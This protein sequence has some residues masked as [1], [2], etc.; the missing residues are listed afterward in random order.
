MRVCVLYQPWA[1]LAARTL[2]RQALWLGVETPKPLLHASHTY[3][4]MYDDM[5]SVWVRCMVRQQALWPGVEPLLDLVL[6]TFH[7]YAYGGY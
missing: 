5:H 2:P 1:W 3:P 7:G 6:H 4:H